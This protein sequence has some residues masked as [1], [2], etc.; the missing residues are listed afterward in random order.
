MGHRISEE[1]RYLQFQVDELRSTLTISGQSGLV[2][3]V[4]FSEADADV[5]D[6]LSHFHI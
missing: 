4:D 1:A 2:I 6:F 5:L 3:V